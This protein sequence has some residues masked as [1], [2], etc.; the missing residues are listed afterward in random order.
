MSVKY[1]ELDNLNEKSKEVLVKKTMDVINQLKSKDYTKYLDLV[2]AIPEAL[3]VT[4]ESSELHKQRPKEGVDMN[5]HPV[6]PIRGQIY[7]ALLGENWGSEL[8][9]EHPVIIL[10]NSPGNLFGQKVNVVPIE[11]DGNKVG[12]PYYIQLKNEDLEGSTTLKKNPSRVILSDVLTI[13]KARLG[14]QVGKVCDKK[15][16]EINKVVHDQLALDTSH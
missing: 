3:K 12:K 10:Q 13:D 6:K 15:M 1:S 2:Q 4:Y 9:G 16:K 11:G 7:N 8:S 14:I 5:Q